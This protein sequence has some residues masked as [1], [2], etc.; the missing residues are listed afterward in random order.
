MTIL[1]VGLVCVA[2]TG[3]AESLTVTTTLKDPGAEGV[4]QIIP[5]APEGRESTHAKK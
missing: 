3:D 2:G 5:E 1:Y 4:P